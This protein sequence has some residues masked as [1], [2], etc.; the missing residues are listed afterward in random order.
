MLE[1]DWPT[2]HD[3]IEVITL[4]QYNTRV[5]VLST[6]MLGV[7]AGLIGT[8]LLLRKRSLMGDAL[9]HATLP[10]VAVAFII[11]VALGGT[12]KTLPFLL[13]G[14]GIFGVIGFASVMLIHNYTRLKDDAAMGIVLSVFFGA[15]VAL[16]GIVQQ[17]AGGSKAGLESYI[18]GKT[19][20]IVKA[21]A[22]WIGAIA[23]AVVLC[24]IAF[25]KELKILCFDDDY[26]SSQGWPT[27]RLD[28]LMLG[29][30][31]LVTV[32][33]LQAVGLILVIA[34]LIIPPAAA[35]FWT[36]N[37]RAMLI[38]SSII[39]G[40]GCWLGASMSA[41]MSDLPAGAV[42]VIV[43]AMVF[44][45][46]MIFGTKRGIF[47]RQLGHFQLSR[48]IARQH[49]LRAM[50]ELREGRNVGPVRFDALLAKRSW[51]SAHLRRQLNA[52]ER[53][54]M[55]LEE[56]PGQYQLTEKGRKHAARL[57]RNHRLWEM[58][59]VTHADIAPSH[60][61]RDADQ[62]EHVLDADLIER[63]ERLME[64]K[65]QELKVPPSPHAV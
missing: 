55:L 45:F 60:V 29:L 17:M 1:F 46:S 30:V 21:D 9:S 49:V 62:I 19:A 44:V 61:D 27:F 11:M 56:Q 39:G 41:L 65:T 58:Y 36:E 51:S 20:S 18:Y 24:C 2:W 50:F 33:G 40:V 22:L 5:V 37:L 13:L 31:T 12:G 38:A 48:K 26:A 8:F 63:L 23:V 32:I 3:I 54:V 42:I 52:L 4:Q 6:A 14:A 43:N 64:Q 47:I 59:L 16:L 34:L 10:G 7:A 15:G 53:D 35:R 57:V 25:Y 28:L